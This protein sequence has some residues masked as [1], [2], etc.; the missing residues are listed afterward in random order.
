MAATHTHRDE[1]LRI[2]DIL[3]QSVLGNDRQAE[4]LIIGLLAKGHV[5]IQGA[6]GLGKTSL[7]KTMAAAI[8]GIF[9]R[10][11]FT[12]DLLPADILGYSI[13][14]QGSHT[15][16]FHKGAVFTNILLADEINRTT[17]RIQSAL[18]E[19]MNE[20]QVSIDGETYELDPPFFVVATRN[21]LFS[22][23]TFPLPD[24]QLDRFLLSF[25]MERP[26]TTT[27]V[28]I[29]KLHK[30]GGEPSKS[31]DEILSKVA[32]LEAQSAVEA[33]EM[34]ES[35]MHYI[36]ALSEA[37]HESESFGAGVSPRASISLMKAAQ[38]SA[39]LNGRSHV[40]PDDVKEVMPHVFQHRVHLK[41]RFRK[42]GATVRQHLDSILNDVAIP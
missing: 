8:G 14:N 31:I 40:Y 18:L 21:H 28:D 32:V 1:L 30:S 11:Q 38:A 25:G 23:G 17:P 12:P 19:A 7:A 5:L 41:H 13:Y 39:W 2:K 24:S 35:V 29:L 42:A 4:L 27:Q 34:D 33:I 6:P 20:S 22:S 9:K 15:F 36:A 37:T 16:E 26:D 3:S 10:I